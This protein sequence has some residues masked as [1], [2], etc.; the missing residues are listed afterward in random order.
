MARLIAL[1]FEILEQ[2]TRMLE[3]RKPEGE[4]EP[5]VAFTTTSLSHQR[6][7][8]LGRQMTSVSQVRRITFS[9]NDELFGGFFA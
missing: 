2:T 3:E 8:R 4:T 9:V 5:S 1:E 7:S 6:P